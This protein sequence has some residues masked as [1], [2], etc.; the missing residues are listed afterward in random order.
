[1]MKRPSATPF[2]YLLVLLLLSGCNTEPDNGI[3]TK[4]TPNSQTPPSEPETKQ[5]E[6][7]APNVPFTPASTSMQGRWKMKSGLF[8]GTDLPASMVDSTYLRIDG[9]NYDVDVDGNPDKGTLTSDMTAS[10]YKMTIK[11]VEGANA[12]KT[13][14]AIF[15][16]PNANTLRICY[17]L[18]GTDFPKGYESTSENGFFSAVYELQP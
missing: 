11:G 7:S 13:L 2:A 10:P 12:G 3:A 8:N 9:E 14:L 17:D 16:M 6:M 15:E 1:M 4:A 18:T 5:G